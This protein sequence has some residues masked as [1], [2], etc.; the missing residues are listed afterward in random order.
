VSWIDPSYLAVQKRF[1]ALCLVEVFEVVLGQPLL[2]GLPTMC[3][4]LLA[5]IAAAKGRKASVPDEIQKVRL[6]LCPVV[7]V[8][9]LRL[10]NYLF[11]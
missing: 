6:R 10:P 4:E 9:Q 2:S 11:R 5:N 1:K 8:A 3:I 7:K